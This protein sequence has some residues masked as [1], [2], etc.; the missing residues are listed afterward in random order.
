MSLYLEPE[1]TE[2]VRRILHKHGLVE[3]VFVFGSRVRGDHKKYSD[4]DL[5]IKRPFPLE[6]RILVALKNDFEQS[7]LPITVDVVEWSKISEEFQ[8][9]IR[10]DLELVGE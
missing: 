5:L 7:S 4:L 6:A 3:D 2:T 10:S 1:H 9:N 8:N